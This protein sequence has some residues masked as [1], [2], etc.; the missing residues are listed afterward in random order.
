MAHFLSYLIR[1][2]C[3]YFVNKFAAIS[4]QDYRFKHYG[5][6]MSQTQIERQGG[7]PNRAKLCGMFEIHNEGVEL[8]YEGC[9]QIFTQKYA[10]NV[11]ERIPWVDQVIYQRFHVSRTVELAYFRW[12]FDGPSQLIL[13]FWS[14]ILILGNEPMGMTFFMVRAGVDWEFV[15]LDSMVIGSSTDF[16]GLEQCV[17]IIRGV[18]SV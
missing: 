14:L 10:E 16:L 7:S 8:G 1:S 4:T 13:K 6:M 5:N 18:I 9:K 11:R 12:T 3:S 2:F 15:K 17:E